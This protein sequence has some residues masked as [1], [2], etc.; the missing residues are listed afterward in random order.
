METDETAALKLPDDAE[1]LASFSD[2][3]SPYTTI[4]RS[5]DGSV[6]VVNWWYGSPT[7]LAVVRPD[8]TIEVNEE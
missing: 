6:F 8:G 1:E 2:L 4:N 5:P 3:S 7:V